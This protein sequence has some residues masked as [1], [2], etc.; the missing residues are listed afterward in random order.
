MI[1]KTAGWRY[2]ED[3]DKMVQEYIIIGYAATRAEG[4]QMLAEYNKN[5][6]DV[7][8]SKITFQEVYERW[9]KDKFPTISHSNVNGYEASYKVCTALYSKSFKDLKL[10]DLQFVVD[11]CGKNYPTLKKLKS[12]FSQ[13]YEYA[14]KHDIC[15]KDY[16]EFVDIARYRD[17]NPNKRDRDKFSTEQIERLW[18]LSEDP[19]YQIVLMLIYNGCRISEFL[20]LKKEHVHLE[21]QYFDVI[22]SK[23]E[24]GIRKVP[25]A[26]KVLP[27][28]RTWFEGSQCEYL[29]HTPDQKHFDYRN[30]Y[31]SYFTPLMEQLGYTQTPHC[32]RHTCISMLTQA[33][34]DQTMIKKIVGHA[35]AMTLTERVYTHLDI[36]S[37][38]DAINQI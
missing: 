5:P 15:G 9:S 8:A 7:E 25:I 31:D 17:K 24:N 11:T 26:N 30:Y 33:H 22:A 27:F 35:G 2:D 32:T 23:T 20:D 4:L 36:Q 16:S 18:Q 21:E 10:A 1:R 14:M 19:Y 37:L 12:L 13:L 3:K 6:F 38:V 29:L 28:Y 34:V